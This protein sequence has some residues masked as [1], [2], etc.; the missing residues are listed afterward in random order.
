MTRDAVKNRLHRLIGHDSLH[1]WDIEDHIDL[2]AALPEETREEVFR[3]IMAIWPVSYALCFAF[4]NQLAKGLNCLQID[5][6]AAWVNATLDV[7]ENSGLQAASRFL[8][9]VENNFACK[10][11]GTPGLTLEEARGRLQPYLTGLAGYEIAI[12]TGV[13]AY[14]DT[15]TIFLAPEIST[16]DAKEQNFLLYKLT[17]TIQWAFIAN[18]LFRLSIPSDDPLLA[19]LLSKSKPGRAVENLRLLDFCALFPQPKLARDVLLL[20]E[21]VRA[22]AF[23]HRELPGLMR[24][25]APLCE[26]L[27]QLRPALSSLSGPD[28]FVEQLK[29][30]V[31]SGTR[32]GN[33]SRKEVDPGIFD[34]CHP[35]SLTDP[36]A[37]VRNSAAFTIAIYGEL[38]RSHLD[39]RGTPPIPYA[40][41]LKPRQAEQAGK[42]RREESKKL[43]IQALAAYLPESKSEV[44]KTL[45]PPAAQPPARQGEQEQT[46]VIPPG[47]KKESTDSPP[48]PD[49]LSPQTFITLDD[50]ELQLPESLQPLLREIAND[51]GHI[52]PEYISSA[53]QRAGHGRIKG[54]A[55]PSDEAETPTGTSAICYDEWD[56]RRSGFRKNWCTLL[57]KELQPATGTFIAD[58]MHKYRGQLRR[59]R[60]Q[61]EM[62][63]SQQCFVKRQRDGDDIDLDAVIETHADL[64]AGLPVSERLYIRLLRDRR[65]INTIF[66]VDMSSSTEG[67]VLT[68]IK[69]SLVLLCESLSM[70][71]D[72]Y[73]IYGFSGMKRSR[74][75]L[76][77]IK[78]LDEPY[79]DTVR[80]RITAINPMDYTRMGPPIRHA[81]NLLANRDATT[82]LLITL[83]DG[84]PE[85]YDDYKGDYAIEDTRHALIEAKNRGIHPFCITIDRHAHD[86]IA[87]MYGEVNYIVIDKVEKLPGRIPQIYRNLTA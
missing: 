24:D 21:T 85:D 72:Q 82:K 9:E 59:L 53:S 36:A 25:F 50:E 31:I 66:L 27:N 45:I 26:Q 56:F 15:T 38:G 17:T 18:G 12:S 20:A 87:H 4:L 10:L 83:S 52:P 35:A 6:L 68:A 42:K 13:A 67:W 78:H 41:V 40:G 80:N 34:L 39:Y 23:L 32:N 58:T 86:Y 76:Y 29:Q 51:L 47:R 60:R 63:R 30:W 75:E 62:M 57:E 69:E 65:N 64:A 55:G 16:F 19:P 8:A 7:Y 84:K 33:W 71:G 28:Q 11:R 73:A 2:L 22:T 74:S 3:Q 43:F 54:S 79:N 49:L 81:S 14:T 48:P 70:L 46:A 1:F 77:H 5:Q 44:Q 37:S 61:F